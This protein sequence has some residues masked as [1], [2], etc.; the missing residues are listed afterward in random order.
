MSSAPNL[1]V[2]VALLPQQLTTNLL[3][4]QAGRQSGRQAGTRRAPHNALT[5]RHPG[6][7]SAASKLSGRQAGRH[8]CTHARS[9]AAPPRTA[10]RASA[11][12][13]CNTGMWNGCW[14]RLWCNP[15]RSSFAPLALLLLS[16]LT[17]HLAPTAPPRT[18]HSTLRCA[19]AAGTQPREQ[20]EAQAIRQ[21]GRQAR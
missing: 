20:A 15:C 7:S 10:R 2:I 1:T 12:A 4:Q 17:R 19:S 14:L 21:A 5:T 16:L 13:P 3:V 9:T 18:H 8:E 11:A 6:W